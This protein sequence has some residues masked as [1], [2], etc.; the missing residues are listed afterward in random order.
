MV[1]ELKN[2]FFEGK[3][4]SKRDRD[5]YKDLCDNAGLTMKYE[6]EALYFSI[7][8]LMTDNKIVVAE[9]PCAV[10]KSIIFVLFVKHI[11]KV[12]ENAKVI[13]CVP[14]EPLRWQFTRYLA[15][16]IQN[17]KKEKK[18]LAIMLFHELSKFD[19][20]YIKDSYL[21][22]DEGHDFPKK[23]KNKM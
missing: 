5:W 6:Q 17:I 20:K 13:L 23:F 15:D 21:F 1:S 2:V 11:I 10:G 18:G 8:K 12:V 7:K 9:V 4:F 14:T 16:Y 22:I 19:D 3:N